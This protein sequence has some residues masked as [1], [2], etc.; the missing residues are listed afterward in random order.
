M[1]MEECVHNSRDHSGMCCDLVGVVCDLLVYG[2]VDCT[3][4]LTHKGT[5]GERNLGPFTGSARQFAVGFQEIREECGI[6]AISLS[7]SQGDNSETYS[8]TIERLQMDSCLK[9]KS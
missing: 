3:V 7:Y 8:K 1:E 4:D 6:P 9:Q 5:V 2:F